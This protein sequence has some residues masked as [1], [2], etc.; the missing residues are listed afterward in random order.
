MRLNVSTYILTRISIN[1]KIFVCN[2]YSFLAM[3]NLYSNSDNQSG[4]RLVTNCLKK[5][6]KIEIFIIQT[7]FFTK[8]F[9]KLK[10]NSLITKLY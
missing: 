1:N 9:F 8:R 7:C 2:I 4:T 6:G 3:F 10:K 5:K